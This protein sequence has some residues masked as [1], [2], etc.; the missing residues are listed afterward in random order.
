MFLADDPAF[1]FVPLR[2]D[3]SAFPVRHRTES[4]DLVSRGAAPLMA[5]RTYTRDDILDT[6]KTLS[7]VLPKNPRL[8]RA[9]F[10]NLRAVGQATRRVEKIEADYVGF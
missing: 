8:S 7:R 10:K 1:E 4:G 9:A 6:G 3:S 2:L 5:R